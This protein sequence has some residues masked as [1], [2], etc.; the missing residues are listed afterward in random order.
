MSLKV[1]ITGGIGAGKSVVSKIFQT[2]GIPVFNADIEAKRLM[3]ENPDLIV[4]IKKL[5]GKDVYQDG[6]L[7]RPLL[8]KKIFDNERNLKRM[9]DLVHPAVINE[10][11][12]WLMQQSHQPYSIKEAALLFEAGS[13][14]DLDIVILVYAPKKIRI[15]R[16]LMRDT[17]RSISD[18]ESIM[19][20]Q[21]SDNRKKK[22]SDYIIIND[23]QKMV[24]PQVLDIHEKI[25]REKK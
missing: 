12:S 18:V 15:N 7:N 8:A 16:V 25:L 21:M 1:G 13:Y 4:E 24:T 23:E 3:N 5:F 19:E 22:H 20:K 10:Y 14:K 11:N 17:H 9:N 2:L 6:A